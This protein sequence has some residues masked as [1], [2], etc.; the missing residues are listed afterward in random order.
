MHTNLLKIQILGKMYII[1]E[2]I[3]NIIF[4]LFDYI[5]LKIFFHLKLPKNLIIIDMP[6]ILIPD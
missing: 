4:Y 5:S 6:R 1:D 2:I 3:T